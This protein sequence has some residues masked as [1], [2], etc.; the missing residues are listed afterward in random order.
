MQLTKRE[1]EI[2]E[3]LSKDLTNKQIGEKLG[4]SKRTCETHLQN[5]Y[6]KMGL[7][8]MSN[9]ERAIIRYRVIKKIGG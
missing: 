4:I 6:K 3:L 8:N 5:I 1:I 7:Q 2:L 9:R